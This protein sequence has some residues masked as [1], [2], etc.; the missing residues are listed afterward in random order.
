MNKRELFFASLEGETQEVPS[1]TMAFFNIATAQ[2]LLGEENVTNEY[3]PTDEYKLGASSTEGRERNIRFAQ[4]TDNF[5]I[6]V[7]K[8]ASFAFGH[9][10]AGE[11]LEK[12]IQKDVE[13]YISEY[14]TG[15]KKLTKYSPH[16]YH[17]YDHP[18]QTLT[19]EISLPNPKDAKRYEGLRE[20]SE[21]YKASGY[22]S[23]ANLNGIFSGIHYFLYPYDKLFSDMILEPDA[24][25]AVIKKLAEFNLCS[26]EELLRCGVDCINFC[27]DLGDGRTLL[28][29]KDMYKDYFFEYHAQLATLCHDYGAKLHMHSHGNINMLLPTLIEAGIDLI[30]PLDPDEIG[31][32]RE[33]KE[34]Y[35]EKIMLVGGI[36]KH[37]FDWD[38]D[39]MFTELSTVIKEGRK[40]GRFALMDSGGIPENITLEKYN[41]YNKISRELRR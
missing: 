33:L 23:Y 35:G 11:F 15:V 36:N 10:G 22:V 32:M 13:G 20:E 12:I 16:F 30:N 27:D 3:L 6:G 34:R 7:G 39:K 8:G 24:L 26:A 37:F 9:G 1:Y 29:S 38:N 2:R 21:F 4:V 18:M 25:K 40:G 31:D 14:E 5:A 28:F 17:N 41:Y 19:D